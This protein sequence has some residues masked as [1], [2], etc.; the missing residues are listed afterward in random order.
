[1]RVALSH[2][3]LNGM[4]GGEKCLEEFCRMYPGSP[5]YTLFCQ[6]DKISELLTRHPIRTSPLQ[7]LP[8]TFQ[9]YRYYLPLF[10]A[11]VQS[12]RVKNV[13]LIISTSHC[14]AKGI[15]KENGALHLS[16]CF[17]PMRYAWDFFEEYFG[18]KDRLAQS[19][20]RK[21]LK[22]LRKWDQDSSDQVDHFVAI[23][24]H[25]QK[26]IWNAYQREAD[27]VYPPV[28]TDFYSPNGRERED[29]YLLAS[30]LVPYKRV[31]LAIDAF[32]RLGRRLVVIGEGPDK[33]ALEKRAQDNISFL[34]WQSDEVL[35][36]H[37]QRAQ[38]LI[39]PG[40]EDFGIIPVEAQACGM[41]VIAFAAGG[42]LE[43]IRGHE[44]GLF[45]REQTVDALVSAVMEFEKM[46]WDRNKI[47]E[48]A[49][50]FNKD[51]FRTQMQAVIERL[52]AQRGAGA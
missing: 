4:R 44:T 32:N 51:R 23:S 48:N 3:W 40:E 27:V 33:E 50:Q 43:T 45:F 25:V 14:V 6:K 19:L 37:Y 42:A 11:A 36:E 2:D 7:F 46:T 49:T 16:Y 47:R 10:P 5:I 30:A 12:F 38:G 29:F 39:F 35:R 22:G 15:R 17:T 41:P 24:R 9:H 8:Q 26:R 13:D 1:M 20:I 52:L 28:D 21:L 34:G 18:K 31:D